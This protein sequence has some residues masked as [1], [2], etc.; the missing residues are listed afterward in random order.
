MM[1]M[2][3]INSSHILAGAVAVT[4]AGPAKDER[5]HH[6]AADV[7]IGEAGEHRVRASVTADDQQYDR[8]D[9]H[10]DGDRLGSDS[11]HA[12]G[13]HSDE[14]RNHRH[15]AMV[16]NEQSHQ[17]PQSNK[18]PWTTAHVIIGRREVGAD[19]RSTVSSSIDDVRNHFCG[20]G[21]EA[22]AGSA[23]CPR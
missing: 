6:T 2:Q 11:R 9:R 23:A 13:S 5:Y 20:R 7:A 12:S 16:P 10:R 19:P 21:L 1:T 15:R 17:Q 14:N 4:A 8:G 3:D 18:V 22:Q